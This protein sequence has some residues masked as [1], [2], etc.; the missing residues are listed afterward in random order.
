MARGKWAPPGISM[1]DLTVWLLQKVNKVKRKMDIKQKRRMSFTDQVDSP[2]H[3]VDYNDDVVV[4][5]GTAREDAPLVDEGGGVRRRQS[6]ISRSPTPG[7]PSKTRHGHGA[8][9]G[10]ISRRTLIVML[11]VE[12]VVLLGLAGGFAWAMY[13]RFGA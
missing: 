5:V 2:V 1:R 10:G 9:G 3:D 8:G 7:T 4:D 11:V 12:S 6:P 13:E